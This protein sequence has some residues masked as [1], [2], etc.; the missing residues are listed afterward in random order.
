[1]ATKKRSLDELEFDFMR[2]KIGDMK[3]FQRMTGQAWGSY[4]WQDLGT[5]SAEELGA[6]YYLV[7]RQN[8]P[9][10]TEEEIDEVTMADL[11]AVYS[12]IGREV[13]PQT[14]SETPS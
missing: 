2:V 13:D 8:F 3:V 4:K 10:F 7:M 14:G 12:A 5:A 1:M 6:I 9:T 11:M